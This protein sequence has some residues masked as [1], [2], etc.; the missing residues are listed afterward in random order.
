VTKRSCIEGTGRRL[1]SWVCK[2]NAVEGGE[3]RRDKADGSECRRS[4]SRA[5]GR[6]TPWCL[7]KGVH[8]RG[9]AGERH[10]HQFDK[11][12]SSSWTVQQL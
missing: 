1:S 8:A 7:Q 2:R 12:C 10:E 3:K 5:A 4:D 9:N 11:K 6:M